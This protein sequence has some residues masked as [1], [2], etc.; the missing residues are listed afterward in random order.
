VLLGFEMPEGSDDF[1]Q[2]KTAVEC[3]NTT[4]FSIFFSPSS[5][6]D[7]VP[8]LALSLTA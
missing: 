3:L 1:F 7:P 5:N 8:L 2:R 6:A 4:P